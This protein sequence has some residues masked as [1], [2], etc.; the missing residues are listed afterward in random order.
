[1]AEYKMEE[2]WA[3]EVPHERDLISRTAQDFMGIRS[4]YCIKFLIFEMCIS[5]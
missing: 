3:P 5:S 2:A 1:M 4:F